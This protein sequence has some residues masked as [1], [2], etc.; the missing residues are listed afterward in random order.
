MTHGHKFLVDVSGAC[1]P[2]GTHSTTAVLEDCGSKASKA[3]QG[4]HHSVPEKVPD[5]IADSV[6]KLLSDVTK[7]DREDIYSVLWDFG[8]QF[9]YYVTH[10]L[11]L[12]Q[13]AIYIL[14]YD[15]S[16]N[17]YDRAN[18]PVKQR[19]FHK[20]ED[21]F[22]LKTNL[23]YLDF[24][25]THV[26]S[27]TRDDQNP[28][29]RDH[30]RME[31]DEIYASPKTSR[32]VL[33]EKCPPVFLV[34]THA[35]T[36]YGGGDPCLLAREIFGFLQSKPYRA[37]LFQEIFVV[38]NT[39][40]GSV[41]EC[42]GVMRLR[43]KV[44]AVA[45]ELPQINEVIPI[46]WLRYEKVLQTMKERGDKHISLEKA[47][48]IA[49]EV[50]NINE[51]QEILTLLN[52][53]HDQR[54][55]IHFDDTPSLKNLVVLDS[56]WL[57]DVLKKVI[58]VKPR[59]PKET[60]E[61]Q[62]LW[63]RFEQTGILEEELLEHVWYPLLVQRETSESLIAIM[64]KFSLLCPLPSVNAPCSK[65]YLVPSMLMSLPPEDI[66]KLVSSAQ[67]PSLFLRFDSGLVPAGLFPRLVVK[68]FQL[69]TEAFPSQ[70]FPQLF[71]NFARFFISPDEGS[72][73]VFLC[74]SSSVEV[75]ILN[76]NDSL[77]HLGRLLSKMKV[78]TRSCRG[79]TEMSPAHF[80]RSQLSLMIDSMLNEFFWLKNM[81]CEMS[82][83]CPVCCHQ[84]A[85][86]LCRN[87]CAKRC[88][89]EEC[90]H[91]FSESELYKSTEAIVCI[92]AATAEDNRVSLKQFAPWFT[93]GQEEVSIN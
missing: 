19:R 87:H 78:S 38:D 69:W 39:K 25:M 27:L 68:F 63:E 12:T 40:S 57:V 17:P 52:F 51:D 72:S 43:Q 75:V 92:R 16:Q 14:T 62:T 2:S 6:E 4:D 41:S 89:Q 46:R 42:P 90:L 30:Q 77:T 23:D 13:R 84:G 10:P 53:L 56:Q 28:S 20:V 18:P 81:R 65:Q 24:W 55:L 85:V 91:F 26:A 15:L 86:N 34:F 48:Q 64:E 36:P 49:A 11:F 83:L 76:V 9:V 5:A 8:G 35:D 88:K 58:T 80:V 60:T 93:F 73:V 71:H 33:P 29:K 54:V 32:S 44:F 66:I 7:E 82:F 37:H 45:K 21:T 3:E 59:D 50:C 47:K 67:L 70:P 31:D 74:H 79:N 1:N 61:Y 22:C